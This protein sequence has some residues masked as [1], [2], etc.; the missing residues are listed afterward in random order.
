[1][2]RKTCTTR[3]NWALATVLWL[4]SL[5]VLFALNGESG[6][7][8]FDPFALEA[9]DSVVVTIESPNM[10]SVYIPGRPPPRS[11]FQPQPW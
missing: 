1:V 11:P 9:L 6:A 8:S 2:R 4:S 7:Q 3:K 10:S 5:L